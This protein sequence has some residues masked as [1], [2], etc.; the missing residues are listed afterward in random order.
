MKSVFKS[1]S[2]TTVFII[3]ILA[4][5]QNGF[6]QKTKWDSTYRPGNYKPNWDQFKLFKQASTDVVFLGNSITANTDWAELLDLPQAKNRG[7]S[8]DITYGVLERLGDIISGKPAK[9]FVL[10]GIN[11]VSRNIPDS[12]IIANHK[13]IISRIKAG[14]PGTK[15]YFYTLLP[16]NSSFNKFPN[17]YNK[18]EHILAINEAIRNYAKAF[19]ITVIDLY[20]N[21]LDEQNH[22]KAEYTLD[23]LHLTAAGYKVWADLLKK[24]NY[25]K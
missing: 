19:K 2:F 22:L 7:I 18:D 12:L 9:V 23:G 24:S 13:K 1:I 4:L 10:I 3:L 15:I 20:P 17:H 11:D 25:L 6:A 14:S 16:V 21:F 5:A 8:G